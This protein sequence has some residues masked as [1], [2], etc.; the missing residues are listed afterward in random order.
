MRRLLA[1]ALLFGCARRSEFDRRFEL[2]S[3]DVPAAILYREGAGAA[4]GGNVRATNR[5]DHAP[6][7][8]ARSLTDVAS[9]VAD[10]LPAVKFCYQRAVDAGASPSGKAILNLSISADGKVSDARVEAPDFEGSE[11][12]SCVSARA[13]QWTFPP[14]QKARSVS[15]PFVFMAG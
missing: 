11:L 6:P 4:M 14:A 15:Y 1:L 5:K 7:A 8:H 12:P 10:K 9:V 13:R 3:A 2:A